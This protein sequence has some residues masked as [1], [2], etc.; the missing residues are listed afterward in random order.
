[1]RLLCLLILTSALIVGCED[2]DDE[3]PI[4]I[5]TWL[6][7]YPGSGGEVGSICATRDGGCAAAEQ[8]FPNSNI[9]VFDSDGDLL[10]EISPSKYT[11]EKIYS[12]VVAQDGSIYATGSATLPLRWYVMKLTP[13]E[14]TPS[15]TT[16]SLPDTFG[17]GFC[18]IESH[19]DNLLL[20]G[21]DNGDICIVKMNK[22]L[23]SLLWRTTLDELNGNTYAI[24]E[25]P[26]GR[27]IAAGGRGGFMHVLS[28]TASG[29]VQ[30]ER[31]VN[32][33]GYFKDMAISNNKIFAVAPS[34]SVGTLAVFDFDLNLDTLISVS[35]TGHV[36]LSGVALGSNGMPTLVATRYLQ[37]GSDGDIWIRQYSQDGEIRWT[38]TFFLSTNERGYAIAAAP[39]GGYF[40]LGGTPLE[41]DMYL[42]KVNDRGEM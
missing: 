37:T 3:A 36:Y 21:T 22:G 5:D 1:M 38:K 27:I 35:D 20:G 41:L 25:L 15:E 42:I 16:I 13:Q 9:Y 23:D 11:T 34:G 31:Q 30:T 14:I 39:D 4:T 7:I 17:A 28:L 12:L 40:V 19:D 2:K 6:R 26:D 24:E 18:I 29:E 33:P 32:L 8:Q 10:Q